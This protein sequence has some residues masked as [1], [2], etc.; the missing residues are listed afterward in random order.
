MHPHRG[1]VCARTMPWTVPYNVMY[2]KLD[3][4]YQLNSS[5]DMVTAPPGMPL[6][7]GGCSGRNRWA[8]PPGVASW[9]R[10]RRNYFNLTYVSV[11]EH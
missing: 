9:G 5:I 7:S 6:V 11:L 8:G 4:Y 1:H 3:M 2:I 10:A